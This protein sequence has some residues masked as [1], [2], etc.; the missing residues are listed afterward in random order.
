MGPSGIDYKEDFWEYRK[1]LASAAPAAC[2]KL[3]NWYNKR[4]FNSRKGQL[5]IAASLVLDLVQVQ[6]RVPAL[7][8]G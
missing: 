7:V 1:F 6:V 5:L 8:S 3:Y 2:Q 4:I